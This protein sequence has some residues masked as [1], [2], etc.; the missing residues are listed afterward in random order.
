MNGAAE[1]KNIF[2]DEIANKP[3]SVGQISKKPVTLVTKWLLCWLQIFLRIRV[4]LGSAIIT[5]ITFSGV[6]LEIF[7]V[8]V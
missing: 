8:G 5:A 3:R 6:F 1:C 4:Y 7:I 2:L